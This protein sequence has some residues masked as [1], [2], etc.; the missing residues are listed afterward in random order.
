MIILI[1]AYHCKLII[2]HSF[3]VQFA[4]WITIAGIDGNNKVG[5]S[6]IVLS[7]G[8]VDDEDMGDVI[9]YTG[10]GG[11][12]N[13]GKQVADQSWDS[14]GN[15]AL[16]ISELH[17]LPVRVTRGA[18]H[19]SIYSPK[20][21][22]QYDGLYFVTS[23]F[24]EIGKDG[25]TICRYRLE[26][27]RSIVQNNDFN[28]ETKRQQTTILRIVRDSKIS[29]KVKELY[30][31]S[32]QICNFTIAVKSVM[33]AEGAHIKPLGIPHNGRDKL[34]NLLC[35]CP[36][37]HVMLDKG[38][39]AIADDLTLIGIPGSLKMQPSH[40]LERDNLAYHRSHVFINHE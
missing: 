13:G 4:Y 18:N 35:L 23:H 19:K 10:H 9:I 3:Q 32:C 29:R 7:G 11:N 14:R 31:Y 24:E 33:Y 6:S 26:K 30:G 28:N 21:G 2:V 5:S 27:E 20:V 25:Y 37:H 34:D 8:Y 40:I 38:A 22:Y 12:P 1:N 16:I 36:N 15:K 17:G 39:F